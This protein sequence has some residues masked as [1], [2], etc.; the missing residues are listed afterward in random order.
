MNGNNQPRISKIVNGWAAYGYGW[1]VH[2]A[3][4]E[5]VIEKFWEREKFYKELSKRPYWYNNPENP[6][7]IN[8]GE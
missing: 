1:A 7:R 4:K 6:N 3:R 5:E 8:A 2:A